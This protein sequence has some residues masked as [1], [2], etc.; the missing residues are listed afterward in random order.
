VF[1]RGYD[2]PDWAARAWAEATAAAGLEAAPW[3]VHVGR[4]DGQPVAC[5]IAL[6]GG[7]AV[8]LYGVATV[9][10]A[11]GRGIGAAITLAPLVEAAAEGH[12]HAVLFSSDMGL[13]VYR[14][15]GFAEPGVSISRYLW[16]GPAGE[17]LFEALED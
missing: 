3:R 4:L 2:V 9:P 12:R 14:R 11:R 6:V 17:V 1:T 16:L 10:E 13:P 5:A 15:L 8:G 7:G